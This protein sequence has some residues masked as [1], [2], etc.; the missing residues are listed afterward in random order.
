M[1]PC[2]SYRLYQIE[3]VKSP[4]EVHRADEQAAR[5]AS[6][7]SSLFRAI[8]WPAGAIRRPSLAGTHSMPRPA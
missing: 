5:L 2:N 7:V 4:A 1:M 6:A 8:P 3:R